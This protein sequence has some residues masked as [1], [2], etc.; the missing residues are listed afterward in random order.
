MFKK[1][2]RKA[3]GAGYKNEQVEKWKEG[4]ADFVALQQEKDNLNSSFTR[5]ANGQR[6]AGHQSRNGNSQLKDSICRYKT[7]QGF[8]VNRKKPAG[9]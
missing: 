6:K 7:V 2:S 3:C 9:I 8:Q 4:I 1:L 5:T